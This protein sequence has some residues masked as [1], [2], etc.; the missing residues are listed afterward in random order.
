MGLI[1]PDVELINLKDEILV[2]EGFRKEEARKTKVRILADS[3]AIR[4]TINEEIKQKLG[5]RRGI[6]LTVTLADGSLK[7]VESV[8]GIKVRFKDRTCEVDAF[9]M[10]G[11]AEPLLGAVPMELMDLALMPAEQKLDYNP[12]HPNGPVF[13]LK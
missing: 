11:N 2:E 6:D 12:N 4:L 3:G 9:V 10:P 7:T 8:S 1:Y 13:H 5:L